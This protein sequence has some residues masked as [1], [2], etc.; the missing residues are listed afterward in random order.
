ME[1]LRW[2][3]IIAGAALLVW[4]V[5]LGRR[6]V[7]ESAAVRRRSAAAER[8]LE[9]VN[10]PLSN[11]PKQAR[12]K[13]NDVNEDFL[14]DSEIDEVLPKVA[15]DAEPAGIE[16]ELDVSAEFTADELA[17]VDE[18]AD[19]GKPFKKSV[20]SLANAVRKAQSSLSDD[21][22]PYSEG[23][24]EQPAAEPVEEKI[25]TLHVTA[26][27]DRKFRGR[28][29]ESAFELR[30]FKFGEMSIYHYPFEGERIFSVANMVKPGTFDPDKMADFETPGIALF[31]RLPLSLEPGAA[32]E[33]LFREAQ[34]L[35][36]D[37]GGQVRDANRNTMTKQTEQHLR[38]E[39]QE[40][41]FRHKHAAPA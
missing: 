30:G 7:D 16:V 25:V 29:L 4:A 21:L 40:Y 20:K 2:V 6:R 39:I 41:S 33:L 24:M 19:S 14:P 37:I 36:D 15:Y 23:G 28:D 10:V 22:T 35:A 32:F 11:Q 12:T 31:M 8:D 9:D 18:K 27:S 3:L 13:L 34:E 17:E 1:Y 38:D 26:G 5:L